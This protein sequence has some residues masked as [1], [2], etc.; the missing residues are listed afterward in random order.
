MSLCCICKVI[1][2][3]NFFA[4]SGEC[5]KII[6]YSCVGMKKPVFDAISTIPNF[7]WRCNDCMEYKNICKSQNESFMKK[8]SDTLISL[9]ETSSIIKNKIDKLPSSLGSPVINKINKN[10]IEKI[11]NSAR[12]TRSKQNEKD[13]QTMGA[14]KSSNASVES[15]DSNTDVNNSKK[16]F[17]NNNVFIGN[18]NECNNSLRVVEP[19]K[20][21]F[22]SRLHKD[23]GNDDIKN[24]IMEKFKIEDVKVVRIKPR[25]EYEDINYVSF[26]IGVPVK[27]FDQLLQPSS[28]PVGVLIK[29][30]INYQRN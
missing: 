20:W 11:E 15:S 6:H 5:S 16:N 10:K 24:Y 14:S 17:V 13:L 18:N 21:I 2:F 28:W 27:N 19:S 22:I 26:K 12:V 1:V 30:F 29:E 23:I 7:S 3:E 8:I 25:I 4:C 9:N